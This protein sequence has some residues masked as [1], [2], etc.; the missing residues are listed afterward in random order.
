MKD[1]IITNARY[2]HVNQLPRID[3][4]LTA[5]LYV[6]NSTDETSLVRKNQDNDFNSHNLTNKNGN[7]LNTQVVN[8]NQVLTK[9]Y[10]DQCH[11]E[12]ERSRRDVGLN[13]YDES[14]DLVKNIQDKNF[15]D[16]KLT[17]IDSITVNRISI[18]N[19]EV[20]KKYIDDPLINNTILRINQ[21][22]ENYLKVSVGNDTYGLT[23]YDKIQITDT[24]IIKSEKSGGYLLQNL[25]KECNDK[26]IN[27]KISNFYKVTET[28]SPTTASGATSLPPIGDPFM[29]I[30]ASSK[31]SG[32]DNSF[33]SFKTNLFDSIY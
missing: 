15:N 8:D 33:C 26:N 31:N 3:S 29:Y 11:Q 27:G 16:I 24:T 30:E 2:I 10:V 7:T 32:S 13:F 18:L 1:K 12:S 20:S 9:A 22:L 23:K 21:T 5:K 14:S 19:E 28:N 17:N 25:K 4:H 6:N